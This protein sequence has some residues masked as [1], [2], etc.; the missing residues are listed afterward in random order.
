MHDEDHGYM[1]ADQDVGIRC[2]ETM[3]DSV[4][5]RNIFKVLTVKIVL[6]SFK[7]L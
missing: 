2:S 7:I 5:D 4:I 1:L 6:D 3:L